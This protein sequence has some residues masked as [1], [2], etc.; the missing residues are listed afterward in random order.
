MDDE[1]IAI[2][3][4]K[5]GCKFCDLEGVDVLSFKIINMPGD[6]HLGAGDGCV[7]N[8]WVVQV[9]DEW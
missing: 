9:D 6:R 3:C 2:Y 1:A 7:G 4:C 8:A 5:I